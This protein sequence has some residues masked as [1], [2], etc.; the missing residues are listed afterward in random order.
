MPIFAIEAGSS[1]IWNRFATKPEYIFGVNKFGQ[2]AKKEELA[3]YLKFT[4]NE[5]L[6]QIAK[7]LEEN[8]S[9]DII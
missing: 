6:E 9:I 4:K 8:D 3:K 1:L 2:S 7:I 5:I